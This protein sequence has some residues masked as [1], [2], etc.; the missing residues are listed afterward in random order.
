[1]EANMKMAKKTFIMVFFIVFEILLLFN[2]H[3]WSAISMPIPDLFVQQEK[4][5]K[6]DG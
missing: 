6:P 3:A 1:M 4:I 5:I 2:G